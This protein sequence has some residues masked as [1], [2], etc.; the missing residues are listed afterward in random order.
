MR[1]FNPKKVKALT[2][3]AGAVSIVAWILFFMLVYLTPAATFH[4][5]STFLFV[6][7]SGASVVTVLQGVGLVEAWLKDEV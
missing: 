6:V 5:L 1:K 3:I 2:Q 4:A 7:A